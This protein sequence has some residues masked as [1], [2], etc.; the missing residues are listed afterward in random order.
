MKKSILLVSFLL[1]F[2]LMYASVELVFW[3]APNPLQESF[4]KETVTRWNSENPDI[5]IDWSTIPAAGSSEE[6]IL[7][8]I[9]SGKV[10][11][12]CTNIFSGFAA[13]LIEAQQ[14]VPLE[15]LDG[16]W[17]LVETRKMRSVVESW[18]FGES[19]FVFPIY[20]NPIMMWWRMDLLREMGFDKAPRTYSEVYEVSKAYSKTN[21]RFGSLVI[22][23][24]NWNDRWYDFISYYYA[25]TGGK[26]YI[27]LDKGRAL[28]TND[29]GKE[30]ATYIDTM[31]RNNW[32]AADLGTNPL[33]FGGVL[34]GMKGPWEIDWAKNQFPDIFED[35]AITPPPVPDNYPS[36]E[37]IYT[38]ADTKGLVMFNQS[39]HKEEA[40]K[41]IKWV[42][43]NI[44]NDKRWV[45]MTNLPPAREDLTINPVFVSYMDANPKFAAYAKNVAY[46]VPPVLTTMTVDVQDIMT[47]YLVEPIMYGKSTV[48]NAL[49]NASSKIRKVLW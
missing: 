8:S 48:D 18:K 29:E 20:S 26:S 37:P 42:Y 36:D 14:L 49:K 44:D 30:V 21:E 6:A 16:F 28:F 23:G 43:S 5:Q 11:D 10:P 39:K 3:T 25:A 34:A 24:R 9:A 1:I 7:T 13:Q 22:M 33:Y 45:E 40:W 19:Y 46:A 4:W 38:F 32:T 41:F 47:Q 35:I 2:G 17:D 15:T 12:I 31:F 27:D